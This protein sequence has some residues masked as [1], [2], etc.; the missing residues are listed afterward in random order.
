MVPKNGKRADGPAFT[1]HPLPPFDEYARHCTFSS[2]Q[3]PGSSGI[4]G[5]T[6]ARPLAKENPANF[7]RASLFPTPYIGPPKRRGRPRKGLVNP[8]VDNESM[9]DNYSVSQQSTV[10]EVTPECSDVT[11]DDEPTSSQESTNSTQETSDIN[12]PSP[13]PSSHQAIDPIDAIQTPRILAALSSNIPSNELKPQQNPQLIEALRAYLHT[14]E[15]EQAATKTPVSSE[16]EQSSGINTQPQETCLNHSSDIIS[17]D[18]EKENCKPLETQLPSASEFTKRITGAAPNEKHAGTKAHTDS[19]Q[20]MKPRKRRLSE[21]A[22]DVASRTKRRPSCGPKEVID[23][24]SI[25]QVSS[26]WGGLRVRSDSSLHSSNSSKLVS[27]APRIPTECRTSEQRPFFRSTT[28]QPIVARKGPFVVPEWARGVPAPAPPTRPVVEKGT[29]G[30]S[31]KKRAS[32]LA[33]LGGN[34][35]SKHNVSRREASNNQSPK[36]SPTR[37]SSQSCRSPNPVKYPFVAQSSPLA[38]SSHSSF[39]LAFKTSP[40]RPSFTRTTASDSRVPLTPSSRINRSPSTN[41]SM[42]DSLFTPSP[43]KSSSSS[44]NRRPYLNALNL[45]DSPTPAKKIFRSA[46]RVGEIATKLFV[47]DDCSSA[48]V[49]TAASVQSASKDCLDKP[50]LSSSDDSTLDQNGVIEL[51]L[52][53]ESTVVNFT[54]IHDWSSLDLPPSSPPP[55]SSP[56]LVAVETDLPCSDILSPDAEDVTNALESIHAKTLLA[57]VDQL[58]SEANEGEYLPSDFSKEHLQSALD[59][60]DFDQICAELS[61]P[62]YDSSIF[63]QI[64]QVPGLETDVSSSFDSVNFSDALDLIGDTMSPAFSSTVASESQKDWL[65]QL[66]PSLEIGEFNITGATSYDNLEICGVTDFMPSML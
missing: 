62:L 7:T 40:C 33:R 36:R 52:S 51:P 66:L 42:H 19:Q 9:T 14:L 53:S 22:E 50:S 23:V 45:P 32:G 35:K 8:N 41:T 63:D 47:A 64:G 65:G 48:P 60:S 30:P 5:E 3:F 61:L 12:S 26:G 2:N 18:A 1:S 31:K 38:G 49:K 44:T 34:G 24:D 46:H 17:T 11:P 29:V 28:S 59:L 55:P 6:V 57:D 16:S 13:S 54:K 56:A 43:E 25:A 39:Y 15:S 27:N 58:I 10:S 37:M 4:Q 20:F 21:T